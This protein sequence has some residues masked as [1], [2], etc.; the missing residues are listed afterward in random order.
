MKSKLTTK[1]AIGDSI[2]RVEDDRLLKGDG[3]FVDDLSLPDML[4]AQF[5]R[6]PHA[7][8]KIKN[9]DVTRAL[10]AKGV[11]LAITGG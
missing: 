1:A 3:R 7:H 10:S 8:A 11:Y 2:A 5:I 4:F 6:S 9:T